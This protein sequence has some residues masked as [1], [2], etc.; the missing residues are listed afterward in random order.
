MTQTDTN[1][2]GPL[3]TDLYE[4]TMAAVYFDH[5]VFADATFSLFIRPSEKRNY[6][7]A[8]GLEDAL[9]EL[10]QFHFTAEEIDYLKSKALFSED[11]LTYLKSLHFTGQ[12]Q[13][14]PEGSIFFGDEPIL[15][16]T[17]PIIEAQILETFLINTIGFQTLIATK[18]ARCIHAAQGRPLIDF[19]LRRTQGQDAGLK[20]AR[21]TYL[22]GFSATSNVLAGKLYSIPISGTMAHSFITAFDSELA[23]FNAYA[24]TFPHNAIFLIDT[25]NTL[26]G[27][28]NAARVAIK[29]KQNGRNLFGVR[30]DSGDMAELSI[31]VRQTLDDAGLPDVK[32][33]ASSGFDEFKMADTL[34]KEAKID[35]FGVGTKMGVSADAPYLDI[36][37]K[38]VRCNDLDVKKLS[39]GKRTLAGK[40]QVFRKRDKSGMYLEDVIGIRGERIENTWALLEL[41]ME[42]GKQQIDSPSLQALQERFQHN[43]AALDEKHK[44]LKSQK[45]YPVKLSQRLEELQLGPQ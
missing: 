23:A 32:I 20:V 26:E 21:S 2:I 16:I 36:V 6:F 44:V 29:M 9:R 1:R 27:A 10:V 8:A 28:R 43:F 19:S 3:F 37:Y 31:A 24:E 41:V 14:L 13:A 15:E 39:P 18:A 45:K 22:A 7:V 11:F 42:S 4:L 25:F 35:A 38:M 40:K 5:Q 17:A 34:A 33:F 30:L 12:V